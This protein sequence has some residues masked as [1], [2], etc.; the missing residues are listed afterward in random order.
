MKPWLL[1]NGPWEVEKLDW[2]QPAR[3]ASYA[4]WLRSSPSAREPV[5]GPFDSAA[6][7]KEAARML[8]TGSGLA[9]TLP[10]CG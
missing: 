1:T 5:V 8:A 6:Q 10:E 9:E 7:A 4:L 3:P 2:M